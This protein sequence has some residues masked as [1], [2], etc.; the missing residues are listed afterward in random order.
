MALG[1]P[2]GSKGKVLAYILRFCRV[3]FPS[4][5]ATPLRALRSGLGARPTALAAIRGGDCH[6]PS[7]VEENWCRLRYKRET[8]ADHQTWRYWRLTTLCKKTGAGPP[9]VKGDLKG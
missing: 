3:L 8:G 6:W 7:C 2:T 5:V 9:Y 4:K 1:L